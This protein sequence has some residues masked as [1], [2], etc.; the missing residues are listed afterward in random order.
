MSKPMTYLR[1]WRQAIN[2]I[3]YMWETN[4]WSLSESSIFMAQ[5]SN[6]HYCVKSQIWENLVW[7]WYNAMWTLRTYLSICLSWFITRVIFV[8]NH[9]NWIGLVEKCIE[10]F[11]NEWTIFKLYMFLTNMIYQLIYYFIRIQVGYGRRF[12]IGTWL[13]TLEVFKC[14]WGLRVDPINLLLEYS[15]YTCIYTRVHGFIL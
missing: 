3:H 14:S 6:L 7:S 5:L 4:R 1:N 12:A 15:I 8:N 13:L 9:L 11:S 2:S 10:T